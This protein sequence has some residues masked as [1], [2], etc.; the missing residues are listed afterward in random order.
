MGILKVFELLWQTKIFHFSVVKQ[1]LVLFYFKFSQFSDNIYLLQEYVVSQTISE[2]VHWVNFWY[3]W[4][5]LCYFG[6]IRF[7]ETTNSRSV[8]SIF[9][10]LYTCLGFCINKF[11]SYIWIEMIINSKIT[12]PLWGDQFYTNKLLQYFT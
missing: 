2:I 7:S 8:G 5:I 3:F 12:Q 4:I 9:L 11:F 1:M 10:V 6:K